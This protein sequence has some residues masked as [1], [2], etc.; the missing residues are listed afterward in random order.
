M[1]LKSPLTKTLIDCCVN[2]ESQTVKHC[3][4]SRRVLEAAG[5]SRIMTNLDFF[6]LVLKDTK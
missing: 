3:L 1:Y 5:T 6:F 2:V 4:D